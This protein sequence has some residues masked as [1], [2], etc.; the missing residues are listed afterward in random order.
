MK[1]KYVQK[2]RLLAHLPPL[3]HTRHE[4]EIVLLVCCEDEAD[5]TKRHHGIRHRVLIPL[6][7]IRV[8]QGLENAFPLLEIPPEGWISQRFQL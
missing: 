4:I 6:K 1:G 5:A 8:A 3:F 2:Q 7:I